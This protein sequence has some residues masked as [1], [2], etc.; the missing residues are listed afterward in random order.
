MTAELS[1]NVSGSTWVRHLDRRQLASSEP[2][3]LLERRQQAREAFE[4]RGLPTTAQERW[5]F[6]P[7]AK[8][9]D[10]GID[11]VE[12]DAGALTSD[13]PL[14]REGSAG[15]VLRL[16]DGAPAP[17]EAKLP[18]G[19]RVLS[20]RRALTE[21]PQLLEPHLLRLDA[22]RDGFSAANATSFV[23]GWFIMADPGKVI[24]S[25]VTIQ[26]DDRPFRE[27]RISMPRVLVVASPA[28]RLRILERR[29]GANA[30]AGQIC[31]SV[32]EMAVGAGA[33][34]EHTRLVARRDAAI[35]IGVTAVEVAQRGRYHSFSASLS[36]RFVRHALEVT[37]AERD[38]QC[39]LDGL[40]AVGGSDLTD[41][42]TLVIHSSENGTTREAYRGLVDD[43]G[44]AVFDGTIVVKAGAQRTQAHQENR[45]LVLSPQAVIH[46]KPHLEIDADD[47]LCSHGATV[48]SIDA[49]QLFYL[50]S[51][52]LDQRLARE[53][54]IR[55]FADE[56]LE[57]CPIAGLSDEMKL[58]LSGRRSDSLGGKS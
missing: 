14:A 25:L 22:W 30:P 26:I 38:A 39:T 47:V 52:G 2:P 15:V 16:V 49:D 29:Q 27:A 43:K 8:Y 12:V 24:D 45:N 48:G 33:E 23:D 55:A 57:R 50:R 42:H 9:A 10:L 19:L 36:G 13:G 21:I 34:L 6:S 4:R 56:I 54:L 31:N 32:M 18:S 44:Q 40:Y 46:A 11:Q 58:Q 1:G 35:D 20:L 37:L 7:V 3:W 28:S 17:L 53:L 41:H 51:R 5:R